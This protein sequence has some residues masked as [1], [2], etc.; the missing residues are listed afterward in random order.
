MSLKLA[1]EAGPSSS[2]VLSL[3]ISAFSRKVGARAQPW[4]PC[5]A[6]PHPALGWGWC[7]GRAVSISSS[8]GGWKSFPLPSQPCQLWGRPGL[9][10]PESWSLLQGRVC[11]DPLH[12]PEALALGT[13]AR[14]GCGGQR[15]PPAP[16]RG[17]HATQSTG[18][19][20]QSCL[21]ASPET[22]FSL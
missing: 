13:A 18:D 8:P 5:P 2:G 16:P 15:P 3:K 14:L 21:E 9:E 10:S 22:A 20:I 17:F 4:R 12:I 7:R 19:G 1:Q 11:A 6:P